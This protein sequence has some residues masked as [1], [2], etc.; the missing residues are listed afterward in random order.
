[1][2]VVS[3]LAGLLALVLLCA[4]AATG[5]PEWKTSEK[6]SIQP[7]NRGLF[8]FNNGVDKV[9]FRP[10]ALGW[11]FITPEVFRR[12]FAMFFDNF[13]VLRR[14]LNNLLQGDVKQSGIELGRF[15]TNTTVG[16]LG[17]F[18]PATGWHMPAKDEDFGQ[19]LAVWRTPSGTYLVIPI[20]GP[21]NPRDGFGM[22][23]DLLLQPPI[24]GWSIVRAINSRSLLDEQIKQLK[25]S[26]LDYYVSVRNLYIQRR[27]AMIANEEIQPEGAPSDDLYE[28][29][30]DWDEEIEE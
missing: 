8:S 14:F 24:P 4:C 6:D 29:E 16:L 26:S 7:V 10:L 2:T 17:F 27:R 21:S 13:D 20:L 11:G 28:I 30:D 3:R 22:I 12:R 18:D 25:E 5:P 23:P 9:L 19:T 15:V 1:V